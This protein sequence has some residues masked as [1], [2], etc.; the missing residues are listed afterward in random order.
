MT[1]HD[2]LHALT[3]GTLVIVGFGIIG[4][5]VRVWVWWWECVGKQEER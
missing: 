3:V 5:V 1:L 2:L 4:G